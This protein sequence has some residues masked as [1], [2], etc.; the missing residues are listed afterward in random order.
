MTPEPAPD[1]P[2]L[3]VLPHPLDQDGAEPAPGL[4]GAANKPE[5]GEAEAPA[6]PVRW[7]MDEKAAIAIEVARGI[8]RQGWHHVPLDKGDRLG[9]SMLKEIVAAAQCTVMPKGR[10]RLQAT[11]E[12]FG[13]IFW[14]MV[15]DALNKRVDEKTPAPQAA[16]EIL[17]GTAE[18]KSEGPAALSSPEAEQPAGV[19]LPANDPLSVIPTDVLVRAAF[20]RILSGLA[21]AT[22]LKQE[23]YELKQLQDYQM[24]EQAKTNDSLRRQIA[25]LHTQLS[26]LQANTARITLP[27]IA[28]VAWHNREFTRTVELAREQGIRAEF[29]YHDKNASPCK[30]SADYAIIMSGASHGWK[31]SIENALPR[32]RIACIDGG[33]SVALPQL[34]LWCPPPA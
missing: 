20:G 2:F 27:K 12:S 7:S 21:A 23:T 24:E 32:D 3:Y 25:E 16:A 4:P 18:T 9:R 1:R 13:D 11:L 10:R 26:T 28:I 29:Q 30:I 34:K 14:K 15:R 8:R 5:G 6:G 17:A 19:V 31:W 33:A 22:E